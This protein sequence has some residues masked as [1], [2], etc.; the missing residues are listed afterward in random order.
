MTQAATTAVGP[1]RVAVAT[2]FAGGTIWLLT[3]E[4]VGTSSDGAVYTLMAL[5]WLHPQAFGSDLF[6]AFGS[7]DSF[8]LFSPLYG[9]LIGVLGLL[10]ANLV[11]LVA[12]HLV[13]LTGAWRLAHRLVRGRA[14]H[15]AYRFICAMPLTYAGWSV[16]GAG[17]PFLTARPFAEGLTMIGVAAVLSRRWLLALAAFA[18]GAAFH[19]IMVLPGLG[20]AFVVMVGRKPVLLWAAPL[21]LAALLGLAMAHVQ[22]FA[23]VLV[24][25]DGAWFSAVNLRNSFVLTS[26]WSALDWARLVCDVTPC[27]AAALWS[28]GARRSLFAGASL[29]AIAGAI[30]SIIGGDVLHDALVVQL[31]LTRCGWLPAVIQFAA[32][33]VVWLRLRRRPLGRL[34][35]VL[36]AEPAF[37][38][39]MEFEKLAWAPALVLSLAGLGLA[40]LTR[41][42]RQPQLSWRVE[43]RLIA[44]AVILPLANLGLQAILMWRVAAFT[45]RL[46]LAL[47]SVPD[48][49]PMRLILLA[50]GCST[51]LMARNR[52]WAAAAAVALAF[53][54]GALTFDAR[55]PWERL[56]LSGRTLPVTRNVPQGAP[57]LW[58]EDAA[59]VWFLTGHPAYVS[60]TQSVGLLFS[61]ATALE[62]MRRRDLIAP[63]LRPT[64]WATPNR[65]HSCAEPGRQVSLAAVE[66]VCARAAGLAGVILD[67]PVAGATGFITR[68]PKETLCNKGADFGVIRTRRFYFLAC[69]TLRAPVGSPQL[70]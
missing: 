10:K 1:R 41:F 36:L 11:L 64:G 49:L 25:M 12:A 4:Y 9:S 62:W 26:N 17:E 18:L 70:R 34:S 2:A 21:G 13:W 28:R 24:V 55:T 45:I 65:G 32:L 67:E 16:F 39:T 33:V 52:P 51:A 42:N 22:P 53:T 63:V 68:A 58:D 3:H 40:G 61:R 57:I 30:V 15:F 6:V 66:A 19:P 44:A 23:R 8:S 5:S 69:D 56:L 7:Q 20:A 50:S 60:E 46:G 43:R 29:M 31:Q 48:F 27:V 59:D 14:G 35:T 54:V 47:P 37:M 38:L